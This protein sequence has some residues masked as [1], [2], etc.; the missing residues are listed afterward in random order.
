MLGVDEVVVE[1]EEVVVDLTAV[2]VLTALPEE[3]ET[4]ELDVVVVVVPV[5]PVEYPTWNMISLGPEYAGVQ[6]DP[7][8]LETRASKPTG[9]P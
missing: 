1:V 9:V 5:V 3:V 8:L 6:D 4:L 7:E 2:L